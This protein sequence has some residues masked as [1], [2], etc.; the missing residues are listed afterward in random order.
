VLFWNRQGGSARIVLN[1]RPLA[2]ASRSSDAEITGSPQTNRRLGDADPR[3][4]SAQWNKKR[5]DA[6]VNLFFTR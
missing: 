1:L 5:T 6:S 4:S 3:R 2:N